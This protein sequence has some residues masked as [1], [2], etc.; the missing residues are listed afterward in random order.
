MISDFNY[1]LIAYICKIYTYIFNHAFSIKKKLTNK[2]I[3][4]QDKNIYKYIK[5]SKKGV[6]TTGPPIH[7]K[8]CLL[9]DHRSGTN[10]EST[11]TN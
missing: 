3:V 7:R 1:I 11:H 6:K 9:T 2:K 10:A 5:K 8:I 4:E